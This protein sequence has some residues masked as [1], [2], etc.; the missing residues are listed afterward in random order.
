[1][2]AKALPW[3]RSRQSLENPIIL[4]KWFPKAPAFGGSGQSPA[5]P[6]EDQSFSVL[7]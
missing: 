5:L 4:I 2:K 6:S 7:V 3:T 1:M